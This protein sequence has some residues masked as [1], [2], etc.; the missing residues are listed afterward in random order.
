[1]AWYFGFF[2]ISGFCSLVYEVV[3]LRLAMAGFGVTTPFV[4]IVLSVFMAG[5]ALGS[6]AAGRLTRWLGAVP[7]R[8]ALRLYAA[9]EAVIGVSGIAVP[10]E[11]GWGRAWLGERAVAWDSSTYY[12]ASGAWIAL[13]LLPYCIAMGATF[14]L[15]MAAMRSLFGERAKQSF[16]YLYVANVLGATAG[17]IGSALVLIELFG[18]RG[19]L[20]VAAMLNGLLAASALALSFGSPA[21]AHAAPGATAKRDRIVATTPSPD[22]AA[23]RLCLF[24]TGLISMGLE[25]VWIRQFTPYLG[26]VVYTFAGILAVYLLATLIGSRL[27]RWVVEARGTGQSSAW[28]GF[29]WMLF[30]LSALLPLAAT[31]PRLPLPGEIRLVLGIAPFCIGA[32]FVTPMLVD[33]RAGADPDRAGRAYAV[34]V[35]GCILGPLLSGFWLLPWLGERWSLVALSLPLFA[36]GLVAVRA[37][38]RLASMAVLERPRAST[39]FAGAVVVSVILLPLTRSF[40]TQF[41]GAEIRRDHT[42]TIVAAGVGR[43]KLLLVNGQGITK[44]TPVTKM[45]AHFPLAALGRPPHDALVVALGMG[46]TFRSLAS[47]DIRA[48][49]VELVPSVPTLFGFFHP[50][51][52]DVVRSPLARIVVDDGR[53]FLERSADRYDVITIDP[54]PPPTA[55]GS[56]LLH[57]R[58]FYAVA[59][60]RLREDGILQQWV[61]GGDPDTIASMTRALM[62]SFPHVRVFNSVEGWG[63]HFLARMT[64]IELPSAD[65]LASR[66]PERARADMIEWGPAATPEAQLRRMLDHELMPTQLMAPA[67]DVPTLSDDRPYNEYFFL[68]W[69]LAGLH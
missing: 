68:R 51:A 6:W 39:V 62:E 65:V 28:A 32:G 49:A 21:T 24:L 9:V 35:I 64:P 44:L 45:M 60:R 4:S 17:T 7:P 66:I 41:P 22:R 43:E 50:D 42:A 56:S 58:E 47:W 1:M 3:W 5:L 27:Y 52:R 20:L 36:L 25:V 30:G 53:R 29:V 33:R 38:E 13:T 26:T 18:F 69:Y 59:K 23:A 48:T 55:A 16:S 11:L 61:P 67:P 63:A 34:N 10:G 19:T 31:D 37:P 15:A 12:L 40:E 54:P 14:P 57:S 8:R 2:V 46:T